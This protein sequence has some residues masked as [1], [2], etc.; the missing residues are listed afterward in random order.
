MSKRI[1]MLMACALVLGP[2]V[3]VASGAE[4]ESPYVEVKT[5]EIEFC[6]S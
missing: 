5:A 1:W 6:R 4:K 2:W 3:L